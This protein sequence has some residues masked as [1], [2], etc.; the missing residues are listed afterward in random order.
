MK[1]ARKKMDRYYSLM[2]SSSAYHIAMI[3]HPGMKLEYFRKQRWLKT[4]IETA[5][6]SELVQDEYITR[7]QKIQEPTSTGDKEKHSNNFTSFGN[8]SIKPLNGEMTELDL[9]LSQPVKNVANPLKWWLT[10]SH[11]FP[12][13]SQMAS[14]YLSIPATSTAVERVFS[15]GRH[16]LSH[17]RNRMKGKTLR[18]HLCLGSWARKGLVDVKDLIQVIQASSKKRKRADVQSVTSGETT[19]VE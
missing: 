5:Q 10:H 14:N 4:W 17:T 8:L 16:L 18:A 19:A 2:D 11:T 12:T 7:Y 15:Q 6:D 13:L 3:L 1:L 9:Y